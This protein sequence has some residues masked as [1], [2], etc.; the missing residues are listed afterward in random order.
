MS[1]LFFFSL[2]QCIVLMV[3]LGGV[4]VW[5][6]ILNHDLAKTLENYDIPN[7]LKAE[8]RQFINDMT[9]YH[10]KSIERPKSKFSDKYHPSI[11]NTS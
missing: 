1:Q 9:N 6:G 5:C 8:A 3:S 2:D 11:E 4:M 7:R 10:N